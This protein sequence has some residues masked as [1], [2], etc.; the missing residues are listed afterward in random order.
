MLDQI[1]RGMP[2]MLW[3]TELK[4]KGDEVVIDGRCT[5]LTALSDFVANL[6]ASGFFKKS[7]E[8]VSSQTEKTPGG[9]LV[10]LSIKAQ[11]QPPTDARPNA[12]GD[13]PASAVRQVA[14]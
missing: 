8:I 14:R 1:S 9:E 2:P 12:A 6:E 5:S 11:F 10:Q 3:L 4:Q 7:I 13:V